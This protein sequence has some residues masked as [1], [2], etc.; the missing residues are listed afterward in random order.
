MISVLVKRRKMENK[1]RDWGEH[2]E[3]MTNEEE[4]AIMR[5]I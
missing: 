3:E 4:D 2:I 5:E 1:E